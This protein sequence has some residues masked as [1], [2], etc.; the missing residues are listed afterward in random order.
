[1]HIIQTLAQKL[2][3]PAR[4]VLHALLTLV[5]VKR[6]FELGTVNNHHRYSFSCTNQNAYILYRH[7]NTI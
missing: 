3:L 4:H 2:F 6:F 1:M 7:I 5:N